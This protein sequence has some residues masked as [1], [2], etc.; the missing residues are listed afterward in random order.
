MVDPLSATTL[1]IVNAPT[2]YDGMAELLAI[3]T[4][5]MVGHA[6]GCGVTVWRD[7][8][9]GFIDADPD[10]EVPSGVLET[11]S[12]AAVDPWADA[13]PD[14]PYRATEAHQLLEALHQLTDGDVVVTPTGASWL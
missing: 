7:L 10:P 9:G 2:L 1:P 4:A 5:L 13:P 3:G 6:I 11:R 14:I 12:Y 8:D